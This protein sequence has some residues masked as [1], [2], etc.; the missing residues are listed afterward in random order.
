MLRVVADRQ[1]AAVDLRD[2]AS[3]RGRRESRASRCSRDTCTTWSPASRSA[4]A[5]P[6]VERISTPSVAR[7]LAKSTS[8]VLSLTL[9]RARS[10]LAHRHSPRLFQRCQRVFAQQDAVVKKPNGVTG[11]IRDRDRERRGAARRRRSNDRRAGRELRLGRPSDR[12]RDQPRHRAARR[13]RAP[14]RS[15]T[16]TWSRSC[17]S[18]AEAET[19]MMKDPFE[20]G[21][22]SIARD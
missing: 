22:E 21:G 11:R 16:A 12:G 1:Q 7:P 3:S 18:S 17:S 2:A 15:A 19:H 5:V 20:L 10:N 14:G 13:V 8:P 6:P 4:L 9:M